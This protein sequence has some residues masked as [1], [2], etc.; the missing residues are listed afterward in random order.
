MN[1]SRIQGPRK[2]V[3]NQTVRRAIVPMEAS[4]QERVAKRAA[5]EEVMAL[6]NKHNTR[7]GN[8]HFRLLRLGRLRGQIAARARAASATDDS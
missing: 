7:A 2:G 1:P 8:K 5:R 6:K 3:P 4:Y